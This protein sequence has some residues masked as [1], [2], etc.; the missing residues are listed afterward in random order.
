M[1][2]NH[3]IKKPMAFTLSTMLTG[4]QARLTLDAM[5]TDRHGKAT[6]LLF[7]NSIRYMGAH[8]TLYLEP[9]TSH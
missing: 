2:G 8:I 9:N 4:S 1:Q 7:L 6:G 3:V 5:A